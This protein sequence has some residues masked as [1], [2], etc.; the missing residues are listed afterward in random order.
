M[1]YPAAIVGNYNIDLIMGPV[2]GFPAWGSEAVINT[3]LPRVAGGAGN[4]AQALGT[5]GVAALPVGIVGRDGYGEQIIST[6]RGLG[7]STTLV[8]QRASSQTGVGFTLLRNDGERA[9]LTYL[10]VLER[11]TD[12]DLLASIPQAIQSK[13]VLFSGYNLLPGL[14]TAGITEFFKIVQGAGCTLL[15]DTG[16]D[17][18]DWEGDTVAKVHRLLPYVDI[19]LPNMAEA[20]AIFGR[21]DK[22]LDWCQRAIIKNGPAGSIYLAKDEQIE[23]KGVRVQAVD[24]TGAGD[25]FNA[26]II[27]GLLQNWSMKRNLAFANRLAA[28]VVS[29]MEDRF[30]SLSKLEITGLE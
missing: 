27:Y 18:R 26:G 25:S 8:E 10:G 21:P 28:Y 6:L 5:L 29:R 16:W 12:A 9:F 14:T 20:R 23:A 15:F 13:V 2:G 30:P 24:T 11:Y 3:A 22:A 7:L 19:F 1:G 17:T 4:T